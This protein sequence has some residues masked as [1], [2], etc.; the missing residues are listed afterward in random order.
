M[1]TKCVC[2]DEPNLCAQMRRCPAKSMSK[3][4]LG[5]IGPLEHVL[6]QVHTTG[7]DILAAPCAKAVLTVG[8]ATR[9]PFQ[10]LLQWFQSRWHRPPGVHINRLSD[11]QEFI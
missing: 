5:S 2:A 6:P 11:L 10:E 4:A 7:M 3:E 1:L 9:V 8:K